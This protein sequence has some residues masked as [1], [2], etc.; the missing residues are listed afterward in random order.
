MD[1]IGAQKVFVTTGRSNTHVDFTVYREG[2][3]AFVDTGSVAVQ[4]IAH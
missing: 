3:G 2:D 1:Y 4:V